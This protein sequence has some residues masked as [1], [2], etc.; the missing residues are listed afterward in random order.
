MW[1]PAKH[2]D[3]ARQTDAERQAPYVNRRIEE[4]SIHSLG[5]LRDQGE[6]SDATRERDNSWDTPQPAAN[7]AEGRKTRAETNIIMARLQSARRQVRASLAAEVEIEVKGRLR[8]Q[9][10]GSAHRT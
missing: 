3:N 9:I 1:V 2:Q 6:T 5:T 10:G 7:S 4:T 8:K